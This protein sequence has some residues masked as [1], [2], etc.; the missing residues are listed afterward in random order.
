MTK[1]KILERRK[2]L[3]A[4]IWFF[5]KVNL[6]AVPLYVLLYLDFSLPTVQTFLA[7]ATARTLQLLGYGVTS[8]N[9]VLTL[10]TT[11][12]IAKVDISV[13]CLGWKSMYALAA[14]TLAVAYPLKKKIK[15]L[16]VA[17]PVLFF[18]NY[19]RMVSTLLFV[20]VYGFR[21]LEIVHTLLWREGLIALVVVVWYL[22]LRQTKYNIL[23]AKLF[24]R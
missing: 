1:K 22:W 8:E 5:I 21:Y 7:T 6:L 15:F 12:E 14:L 16:F 20:L 3:L 11:N 2:K 23:Q 19:L 10:I 18:I 24:F 9:Y 17:L 4:I 13:D